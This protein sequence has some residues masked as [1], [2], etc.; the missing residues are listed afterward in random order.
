[1]TDWQPYRE[2]YR[3]TLTRTLSI[4]L[5]AGAIVALS[6]GGIRRWP[7]LSLLMLWPAFGG[8][9]IDLLFLNW[10]RPRLSDRRSIQLAARVAFWFG[11]GIVLGVGARFT[12]QLLFDR[13]RLV[14]LTWATAGGVF[15]IVE[16]MAHAA[17]SVRGRPSFY[18]GRG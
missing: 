17:L 10:L 16:L 13:P 8:H 12:D 11:G 18:N 2:P 1:M 7:A 15:V 9:L 6:G 4:A 14:S 3:I 5:I